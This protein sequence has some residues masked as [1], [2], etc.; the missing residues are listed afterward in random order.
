MVL[1][2]NY[3]HER[4]A[5]PQALAL[6]QDQNYWLTDVAGSVSL[7]IDGPI[8]LTP[9]N[10]RTNDLR[11]PAGVGKPCSVAFGWC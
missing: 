10:S 2:G 6:S 7:Q 11:L 9:S 3:R 4:S 5:I 8:P 1:T